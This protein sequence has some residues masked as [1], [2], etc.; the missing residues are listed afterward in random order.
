LEYLDS[1]TVNSFLQ[2]LFTLMVA[3]VLG[4]AVGFERESANRPA[5]LRTHTL[6][7]VGSALVMMVS[8]DMY[9]LVLAEGSGFNADPGR[10]AA[11][12]VSGIGFLGAG[13]IMR[14]GATIRGLTT[15]A[16]LWVVAGVG[17]A[18]G[19]AMYMEAVVATVVILLTLKTLSEV[20]RRFIAKGGHYTLII[21]VTD[22]PGRLASL[23]GVCGRWGANIKGVQMR[24]GPVPGTV[25]IQF[26]IK[27][28]GRTQDPAALIA[29]L[30]AVEGVVSVATEE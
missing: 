15:A 17:L 18:A 25:E 22:T 11:Q 12:V 2:T 16:S 9:H 5:G 28:T 3:A 20:E 24:S 7:C 10:I 8:I 27:M 29:D 21:H 23:A 1:V 14:E 19:A 6:V 4:G 13:T 30:M 26:Y